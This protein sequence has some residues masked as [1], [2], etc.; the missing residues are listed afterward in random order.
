MVR[1]L[2]GLFWSGSVVV[3][4]AGVV[5]AQEHIA[6]MPVYSL[7]A[8]SVNSVTIP[9]GPVGTVA[10]APGD[11][12]TAK[13]MIRNWSPS[14]QILRSYQAQFDPSGF[15]SGKSG[16]VQ[17]VGHNPG[18]PNELNA[19]IDLKDP[20]FIHKGL[21]SIPLIDSVSDGYRWLNVI[22][23]AEEGPVSAQ[24]GKKYYCGTVK[25]QAAP[26]A[27]GTF[28]IGLLEEPETSGLL[29]QTNDPILPVG[30]E[31]LTVE[32]RHGIRWMRIESS[33]PPSGAIDGRIT[34][35]SAGK[36]DPAWK[37][38]KLVFNGDAADLS[39]QDFVV[40]DGSPSPPR[41]ARLQ[42]HGSEVVITL[43]HGIRMGAWTTITHKGSGSFSRIGRLPGDAS[44][45]GHIDADDLMVLIR[46]LNGA[47]NL[48]PYRT[49]LDG[50]GNSD[51]RDILRV[52]DLLTDKHPNRTR[53]AK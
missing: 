4:V 22:I 40:E 23:N 11:V 21:Q 5:Q 43:D 38:I 52:I 16:A 20:D 14:G 25:L 3:L 32:V 2:R 10:V 12:I 18:T 33:D 37:T 39:A 19:F 6:L 9:N 45:D 7:E 8:V 50:S 49:D 51:A 1:N 24:D 44:N 28:K 42:G 31:P 35:S 13:I 46:G 41:I 15:K 53:L 27:V 29:D 48:P 30:Y 26:D 47:E 36:A 34:L 17:P